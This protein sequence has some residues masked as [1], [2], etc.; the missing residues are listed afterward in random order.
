MMVK[1]N[2]RVTS[3]DLGIIMDLGIIHIYTLTM[4]VSEQFWLLAICLG[5]Y[6]KAHIIETTTLPP[7]LPGQQKILFD[8]SKC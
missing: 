6:A 5:T 2:S 4:Q 7:E 3:L 8:S 1:T